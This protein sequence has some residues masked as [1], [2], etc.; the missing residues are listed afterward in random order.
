MV[1]DTVNYSLSY[2]DEQAAHW[3][4]DGSTTYAINEG[5]NR[6]RTDIILHINEESEEFLDEHR[7]EEILRK[8]G[9][10]SCSNSVWD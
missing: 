5:Q 10:F 4:C 2:Q 7:I 6:K 8:Y 9:L 3:T 1:A